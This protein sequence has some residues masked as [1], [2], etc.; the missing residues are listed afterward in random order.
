LNLPS[1]DYD[2]PWKEALGEYFEQFLELCFPQVY[3]LI[4]WSQPPQSLDKELQQIVR[5]AESGK[6]IADKLFQVWQRDGS[7][8]WILVHVEVQSQEDADFPKRMYQYHYRSFDLYERQVISLAVL[9]DE[10]SNWRPSHYGYSLAGCELS[11]HFPIVKLLDYKDSWETL[12]QSNNPFAVLIMAHLKTKAT[13][14][15][16]IQRAEWKWYLVRG[17]YER[18]YDREE[19]RKLFR[20][21]DW[22]MVLPEELQQGF[23]RKL[24]QYEEEMQMPLLS[25]M[26]LRAIERGMEQGIEQGSRTNARE[27]VIEVLEVRFSEVPPELVAILNNISDLA[28]LKQLHREA[29]AINS[30]AEFQQL[31]PQSQENQDN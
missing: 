30:I 19:I 6:R 7:Q 14:G 4:D 17:L 10:R 27:S 25:H 12:E 26:E 29:I 15:K 11:F 28:V 16:P 1:A 3:A 20:L 13:T 5:E 22:M 31:L 8:A 21:V 2:N 18:G 23:D 9:G 24:Q